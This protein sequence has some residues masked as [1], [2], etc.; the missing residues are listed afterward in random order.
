MTKV[1]LFSL[2][3]EPRHFYDRLTH[4]IES[5]NPFYNK[6][7]PIGYKGQMDM[8]KLNGQIKSYHRFDCSRKFL[9]Q[10]F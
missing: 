4:W 6:A 9:K 2:G 7:E 8:L 1:D 3:D 5:L 10:E